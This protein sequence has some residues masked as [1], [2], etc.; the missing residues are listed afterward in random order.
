MKKTFFVFVMVIATV[1]SV[2]VKGPEEALAYEPASTPETEIMA[3]MAE[4]EE[5]ALPLI[6]HDRFVVVDS[7]Y[8][9]TNDELVVWTV[10]AYNR[11]TCEV[12]EEQVILSYD[13][14]EANIT[15]IQVG[16]ALGAF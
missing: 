8:Y 6:D 16:S 7:H 12:T 11:D 3:N 2:W 13:E 5:L 15:Y 9:I 10:K 14:I 4:L 1:I